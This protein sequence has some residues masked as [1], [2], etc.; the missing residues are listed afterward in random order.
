MAWKQM[1]WFCKILIVRFKKAQQNLTGTQREV[2]EFILK[3]SII[4]NNRDSIPKPNTTKSHKFV[5]SYL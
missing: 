4:K 5:Q 3:L 2:G 1:A